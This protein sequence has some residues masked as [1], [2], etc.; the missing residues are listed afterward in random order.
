MGLQLLDLLIVLC[1]LLIRSLHSFRFGRLKV[2]K[3]ITRAH[4]VSRIFICT[5][6]FIRALS[7]GNQWIR[8]RFRLGRILI[9]LDTQ[10]TPVPNQTSLRKD[11]QRRVLAVI[12]DDFKHTLIFL[13]LLRIARR[14]MLFHLLL[15]HLLPFVTH[16]N[17]LIL[18]HYPLLPQVRLPFNVTEY[19]LS[20]AFLQLSHF[21]WYHVIWDLVGVLQK[22][23]SG[24]ERFDLSFAHGC[25]DDIDLFLGV[26]LQALVL[27]LFF[28][29]VLRAVLV[30]GEDLI[31]DVAGELGVVKEMLNGNI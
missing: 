30:V 17:H 13:V 1:L 15:G 14:Q 5:I 2:L 24:E 22:P 4:F 18:K 8:N 29:V 21:A 26:N 25:K 31:L 27:A 9:L 19:L 6:I 3:F 23:F 10:L 28:V 7:F 12:G 11:K 20:A 16:L